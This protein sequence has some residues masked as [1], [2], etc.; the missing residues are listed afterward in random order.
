MPTQ[1]PTYAVRYCRDK[2]STKAKFSTQFNC[3][4]LWAVVLFWHVPLELVGKR[5]ITNV[6]V[7]LKQHHHNARLMALLSGLPGWAS[8][9]KVKPIYWSKRK[10]V[11][12][13]S[14]GPNASLHSLQTDNYG[15]T[16]PL[17]FFLQAWCS[18]CHPTTVSKHWRQHDHKN[19]KNFSKI[20]FSQLVVIC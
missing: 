18:S 3:K 4:I 12:V 8:I 5:Y 14:A 6:N 19:E 17:K 9:R 2:F 1:L 7:Q 13:A 20:Q 15:S 10:W 16:P 11:A